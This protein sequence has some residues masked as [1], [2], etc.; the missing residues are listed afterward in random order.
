MGV[1]DS[2]PI[3]HASAADRDCVGHTLGT[4]KPQGSQTYPLKKAAVRLRIFG[5]THP[6]VIFHVVG[7]SRDDMPTVVPGGRQSSRLAQKTPA[8]ISA[9]SIA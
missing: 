3:H 9:G 7:Q 2:G 1:E 4:K 8:L 6:A 5:P